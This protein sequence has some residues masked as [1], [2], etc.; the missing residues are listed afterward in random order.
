MYNRILI[1]KSN[2]INVC[3]K[4]IYKFWYYRNIFMIIY[5]DH[6]TF[7]YWNDNIDT[8][9]KEKKN[10]WIIKVKSIKVQNSIILLK[11]YYSRHTCIRIA[12]FVLKL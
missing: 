3:K 9:E 6:H 11:I 7:V 12:K 10:I 4:S 8:K 1:T 5:G 2:Y